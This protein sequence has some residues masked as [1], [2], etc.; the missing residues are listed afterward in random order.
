MA[1]IAKESSA[2]FAPSGRSRELRLLI[3]LLLLSLILRLL[4]MF[5]LPLIPEEAYYWLYA[6]HPAPSYFDHPPMVAW[7]I[8]LGT[9]L[10]GDSALGVRAVNMLLS[11]AASFALYRFG[12]IWF[13]RGAALLAAAAIQ[14]LPVYFGI[15]LLAT[16]DAALLLFWC[17]TLWAI[18]AAVHSRQGQTSATDNGPRTTDNG[19]PAILPWYFAGLFLG[20]TLLSKYTAI[21]LPLGVLLVLLI[22]RP[23]RRQLLS[24][25]PYLALLLALAIFSPVLIWNR[26]HDWI[27][28]RFQ[29]LQR[30]GGR[31]ANAASFGEFLALQLAVLT[32]TLLVALLAILARLLARKGA[33]A[34]SSA[35]RR[36]RFLRPRYFFA[37]AFSLPLLGAL[38][39]KSL[40]E[41][42]INWTAPAYLSILPAA[43][44]LFL[45][46]ARLRRR[47]IDGFH[48]R[49][50]IFITAIVC[51]LC[52]IAFVLYALTLQPHLPLLA[53]M[54]GP[55]RPLAATVEAQVWKLEKE[56]G[57]TPLVIT[58]DK[59]HLAAILAFYRD[60]IFEQAETS[61][62]D[63]RPL[64]HTAINSPI[65][66]T[67]GRWILNQQYSPADAL[68]FPYW[69]YRDWHGA[70]CIYV[71]SGPIKTNALAASF[72]TIEILPAPIQTSNPPNHRYYLAIGHG[73]KAHTTAG[74]DGK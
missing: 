8:R 6:K 12:R 30:G 32:P 13:S 44:H 9:F 60:E 28:F 74:V 23:F 17:A 18:S 24:P 1:A 34:P 52:N 29:F 64:L 5:L 41:I 56:T 26:R 50:A 2:T 35:R 40:H 49:P 38:T 48:W 61:A 19:G 25:H 72:D 39:L 16:M 68:A 58:A 4:A 63:G 21:F 37:L 31:P 69:I 59:F 51:I 27:S 11:F 20:L 43:A 36:P 42:H 45:A 53:N 54:L 14:I 3:R 67:T 10:F 65:H 62:G 73:L 71:D 15:G 22:D 7:I 33:A 66:T 57:R 55:W 70:D 46:H 47:R